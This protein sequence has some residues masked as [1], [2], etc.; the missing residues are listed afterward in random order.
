VPTRDSESFEVVL[1]PVLT[2][3]RPEKASPEQEGPLAVEPVGYKSVLIKGEPSHV[4]TS[5]DERPLMITDGLVSTEF[6]DSWVEVLTEQAETDYD[7]ELE[8]SWLG[9]KLLDSPDEEVQ[10]SESPA[11]AHISHG[12]SH[13]LYYFLMTF[14]FITLTLLFCL[15]DGLSTPMGPFE[16]AVVLA[17]TP[18]LPVSDDMALGQIFLSL[19][20]LLSW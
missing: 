16:M 11:E 5:P 20:L 13:L 14:L 9:E 2:L 17:S 3:V 10:A 8:E 15:A 18:V 4:S 19:L 6:I 12:T 1:G 7:Y